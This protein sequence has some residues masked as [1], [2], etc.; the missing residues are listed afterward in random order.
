MAARSHF[1]APLLLIVVIALILNASL[2]PFSFNA[3][4]PSFG[5]ALEQ[6]SWARASRREMFNN[7]L[8][9]LPLGFCLALLIEPW[10][11]R[12]AAFAA[13]TAVGALLSLT[14]EITQTLIP[15]RVPSY[16]D[17]ALNTAGA[18]VGAIIGSA[19]NVLRS[20]MA[21]GGNPLA[22]SRAVPLTI[23][24]LW[25]VMR[26]WPLLPDAT[27]AQ[28]KGAVRPLF[29]P[30][31]A[32]AEFVALFVGWLIVAQ[33]V[34]HLARKQR[35]VD[36]FLVVIA[37]VLIGRTITEG[38]ALVPAELAAIG[39]VLPALVLLS[40]F[41]DKRR[42]ALAAAMLGTWLAAHAVVPQWFNGASRVSIDVPVLEE[43][44]QRQQ[45]PLVQV[46]GKGFSYL[47]FGWLLVG[48]GVFP[49]VAAGVTVVFVLLMCML[50]AGA[51]SP[52]YGWIDLV[53]AVVAAII[54]ARWMPRA[55]LAAA[56]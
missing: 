5:A 14:M 8:L 51:T 4:G 13:G 22:R 36:A 10:L 53:I 54:V 52:V 25:L 45:V 35:G 50:Q 3:D 12:I 37:A 2:Y 17:L 49:H 15:T 20:R 16:T 11:G 55:A 46:A 18:L 32:S 44:F 31:V 6:L 56:S 39:V 29:R 1:A 24:L 34:F 33:A 21:P 27:L 28:L 48:A 7:V 43:L 38:N 9:Y 26:L 30:Q 41:D 40:R 47:A 23:V 42:S 19:W